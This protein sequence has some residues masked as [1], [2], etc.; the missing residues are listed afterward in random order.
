MQYSLSNHHVHGIK[1][2]FQYREA[3]AHTNIFSRLFEWCEKQESNR[4]LWLGLTFFAQIG[5][6]VP[7]TAYSI[8]FFG[9]NT[10]LLWIILCTVNVPVLVLNLAAMPTKTTLPLLFFAWLT[11]AALIL[12][13]VVGFL[14]Q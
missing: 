8:I 7:L 5:L 4:F 12:F 6:T 10:F 13:C 11:Q 1:T 9:G 2:P 3:K 14:I